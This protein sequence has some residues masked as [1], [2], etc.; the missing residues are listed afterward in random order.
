MSKRKVILRNCHTLILEP[1]SLQ[2][3]PY[4]RDFVTFGFGSTPKTAEVTRAMMSTGVLPLL[5]LQESKLILFLLSPQD[6]LQQLSYL[7][8]EKTDIS[9]FFCLVISYCYF[10]LAVPGESPQQGRLGN[11]A[12]DSRPQ[13]FETERQVNSQHSSGTV[14]D[15]LRC[16]VKESQFIVWLTSYSLTV[17]YSYSQCKQMK[18][19]ANN[20]RID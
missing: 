6:D 3:L 16:M 1:T 7:Y 9:L 13:Q 14:Y 17:K 12:C 4:F 5:G 20:A 15:R 8:R 18:N 19:V 11:T 10:L 2:L